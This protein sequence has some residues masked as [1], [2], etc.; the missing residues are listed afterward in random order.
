VAAPGRELVAELRPL[1]LPADPCQ[2]TEHQPGELDQW[3][4]WQPSV[5]IPLGQVQRATLP[6]IV[7]VSGYSGWL[8]ARMIPSREAHDILLGTLGCLLELGAVPRNAVPENVPRNIFVVLCPVA[9]CG[10]RSS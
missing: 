8:V 4:L 6:V 3:D 7:G 2:R 9:L 1:Y 10:H 5:K